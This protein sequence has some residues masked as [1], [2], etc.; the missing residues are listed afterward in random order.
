MIRTFLAA[1]LFVASLATANAQFAEQQSYVVGAGTANAQTASFPNATTI[2]DIL[3]VPLRIQA[4]ATNTA[5][6]TLTVNSFSAQNILKPVGNGLGALTGN[7]IISGQ[8]FS[9][10]W[11]GTQFE[12]ISAVNNAGVNQ[13]CQFYNLQVTN[14]AGTPNTSIDITFDGATVVVP[15]SRVGAFVTI[16]SPPLVLNTTT[17][18]V[19]STANG[20]DGE[21]RGSNT[22]VSIW[23]IFNGTTVA[24]LGSLAFPPSLPSLPSGYTY[25]CFA[26]SM[27]TGPSA[28]NAF[29]GSLQRGNEVRYIGGGNGETTVLPQIAANVGSGCSGAS[30][31][32]QP[33]TVRGTSGVAPLWFPPTANIVDLVGTGTIIVAPNAS[34]PG[35]TPTFAP[36]GSFLLEANSIQVCGTGTLYAY[37]W[38]ERVNAN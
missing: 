17:G 35:T 34:F 18:T 14:D 29:Y 22:F 1:L 28:G 15:T 7:E 20:M 19:T 32:W 25:A 16:A 21:A 23:V 27:K 13:G 4:G 8:V 38:K 33:E 5:G 26:G 31:T 6:T 30:P 9:V 10:V 2:A 37:G 11:D 36:T 3:G 12:L 24:S